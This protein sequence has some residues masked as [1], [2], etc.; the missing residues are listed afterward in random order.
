[1]REA[2]AEAGKAFESGEVPVGCVAVLRDK[3]IS[4]A[5]NNRESDSDPTGHAEIIA[6]RE[7][8]RILGSRVLED[9]TLYVTL[10]PCP[11]CMSAIMLSRVGR[12]VFGADDPK[13][14]AVRSRWGLA[15]DPAFGHS[16]RITSGVIE[17]ECREILHR[18]FRKLRD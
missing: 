8:G 15:H 12:L 2:L 11:M 6:L 4:R 3:I 18:F 17:D 16:I 10:E 5:R 1:M 7:A 14:G 9:V 13:L